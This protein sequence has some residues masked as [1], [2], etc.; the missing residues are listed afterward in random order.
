[1]CNSKSVI[2]ALG[3][4]SRVAKEYGFSVQR[5]CNWGVRGIPASVILENSR[6]ADAL[7]AA[8]YKRNG[9]R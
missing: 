7:L 9:L 4:P 1:M 8:G 6:F 3:G 2:A 5:V